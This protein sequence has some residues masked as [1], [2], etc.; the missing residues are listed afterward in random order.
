MG[1]RKVIDEA[2]YSG[3]KTLLW[4]RKSVAIEEGPRSV[5]G[6]YVISRI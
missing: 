1:A 4:A 3:Q 5:H 2:Y 6:L